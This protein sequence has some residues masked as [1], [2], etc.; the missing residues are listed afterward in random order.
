[1]LTFLATVI[2]ESDLQ[3]VTKKKLREQLEARYQASIAEKKAFINQ[4]IDACLADV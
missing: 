4:Q 3:T 2:A 1:L